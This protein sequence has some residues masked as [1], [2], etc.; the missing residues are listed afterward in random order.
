MTKEVKILRDALKKIIA[1]TDWFTSE[2]GIARRA[3]KQADEAK[4]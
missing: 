4:K 2:K 3:L 1:N